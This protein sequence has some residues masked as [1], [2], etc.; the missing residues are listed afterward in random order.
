VGDDQGDGRR[1]EGLEPADEGRQVAGGHLL[2]GQPERRRERRGGLPRPHVLGGDDVG[3]AGAAE[4]IGERL[5][6]RLAGRA[7]GR[8]RRLVGLLRVAN[9][10][11]GLLS[12]GV[13]RRGDHGSRHCSHHGT[14]P[15]R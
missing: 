11:H 5:G 4:Q 15:W 3:D 10:D 6:P 14:A 2:A 12:G 7:E 13:D 1:L 8:V 9:H